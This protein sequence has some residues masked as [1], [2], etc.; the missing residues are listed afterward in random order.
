MSKVYILGYKSKVHVK[1]DKFIQNQNQGDFNLIFL[2]IYWRS[3]PIFFGFGGMWHLEW[4]PII[5][6]LGWRNLM[7]VN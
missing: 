2:L 1:N 3:A 5:T 7:I 4:L 6:S